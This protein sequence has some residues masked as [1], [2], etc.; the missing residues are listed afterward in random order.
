MCLQQGSCLSLAEMSCILIQYWYAYTYWYT[1]LCVFTKGLLWLQMKKK[2][3]KCTKMSIIVAV[4]RVLNLVSYKAH[5]P[6]VFSFPVYMESRSLYMPLWLLYRFLFICL[7]CM[8]DEMKATS[9]F[10][11]RLV[12]G[13]LCVFV[14]FSWE[15]TGKVS[16]Q[17]SNLVMSNTHTHRFVQLYLL[18]HSIYFC[19]LWAA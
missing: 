9:L 14:W 17:W 2:E 15:R 19:S 5:F 13:F 11:L 10:M 4:V 7:F 16:E 8:Y 1:S 12:T 3:N 6:N 18:G